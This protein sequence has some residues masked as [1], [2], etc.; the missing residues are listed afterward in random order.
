MRYLEEQNEKLERQIREAS[1]RHETDLGEDKKAELKR[2]RALVDD[3][4]VAK[5]RSE[6][7]CNN[8][9]GEASEFHWK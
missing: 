2:L 6:V 5:I 7:V 1:G 9:K 4:T 3:A 8:L